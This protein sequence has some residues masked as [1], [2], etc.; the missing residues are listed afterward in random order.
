[1]DTLPEG[2]SVEQ[3]SFDEEADLHKENKTF[4]ATVSTMEP[5]TSSYSASSAWPTGD[6]EESFSELQLRVQ[7]GGALASPES[8]TPPR[9]LPGEALSLEE[10]PRTSGLI[11]FAPSPQVEMSGLEA[12]Q[13][14]E[15]PSTPDMSVVISDCSSSLAAEMFSKEFGSTV[16]S[17]AVVAVALEGNMD[18]DLSESS[19][20]GSSKSSKLV[21][22]YIATELLARSAVPS[23]PSTA[24]SVV[25]SE[26]RGSLRE[27]TAENGLGV[28]HTAEPEA[29][30]SIREEKAENG[31]DVS[32][33]AEPEARESIGAE[34][35]E[36]GLD[37]SQT[38]EPEV[39]EHGREDK[40]ENGLAV[41]PAAEPEGAAEPQA[42]ESIREEKAENGLDVSHPAEPEAENGLDVSQTAEPEAGE[43]TTPNGF[44]AL[45]A[46]LQEEE[47]D[48][49]DPAADDLAEQATFT[50]C[51]TDSV[52]RK[53]IVLLEPPVFDMPVAAA[54]AEASGP[55]SDPPSEATV[56]PEQWPKTKDELH[57]EMDVLAASLTAGLEI[58]AKDGDVATEVATLAPE[59]EEMQEMQALVATEP[60]PPAEEDT[61]RSGASGHTSAGTSELDLAT[62]LVHA[63]CQ[64]HDTP[65]EA[66]SVVVSQAT[67]SV[68]A[69]TMLRSLEATVPAEPLP[70]SKEELLEEVDVLAASLTDGLEPG[71]SRPSGPP[72]EVTIMLEHIPKTKDELLQEMDV[73]AASL[74]AGLDASPGDD[75]A[76]GDLEAEALLPASTS[77]PPSE[78]TVFLEQVPKSQDEL[79][80]E[81]N[82]LAASL[83]AGLAD[84]PSKNHAEDDGAE[85]ATLA[86]E[87]EEMQEMQALVDTEPSPPAAEARDTPRSGASGHTSARS[88][89]LD[90]ATELVH[91]A[92]QAQDTPQEALSVVVSQGTASVDA[93]AM[94]AMVRFSEDEATVPAE[95]LPK[96]KEELLEEVDVLAASLTDGL[97]PGFSRPSGPPSEVTIMLEHIPKTKDE[98]LQEM[99]VLAASLTAGLDASPGDNRAEGDLEAEA[100]LPASTS[101]PPSEAT[102]FLEQVS[103][104]QDELHA[105]INVLAA[106]LTAGLADIPSKNHAEDDAAE[107]ATLAPEQEEMQEMQALV[108]TEPSPPAAEARDTPRS[109]ASGH[110]SARSSELDLATELVHAACQ[111]QDTP[112]EA[113]SVVVSQATAID[114]TEMV[115][116]LQESPEVRPAS[117]GQTSA[118][119]SEL[120]L[121]KEL[122]H[123]ACQAGDTPQEALSVVVSQATESVEATRIRPEEVLV[124]R[125]LDAGTFPASSVDEAT[126]A[127]PL[128]KSKEEL[129]EEVDVLAASLTDG[130]EPGFSRPSGP[131]SEVT[132]MLEH[133]PKT[134]DELL[135]EMDV[136]AASLT[137]GLDASPGDDR[138][139][140]DL[141]A[142]APV[143]ERSSGPP[144]EATVLLEHIPKTKEELLQEM[145]VLAASL[146]AGLDASPGE[147]RAEGG[148]E[149]EALLPAST[150]SPPS[151][152]TVFLEQVPKSQ[153]ELHAEINVL[154]A[155]LTAGLAEIPGKNHAEDDAAEVATLA[156]EQEEMQEM[157]ALVD[158]EP[159]PP[160]AEA[161]DTPRSGASGQ[162]SARTSELDL[163]TE[164]VHAACYA[165]DSPQEAV[166]VVVSQASAAAEAT[167][168]IASLQEKLEARRPSAGQS[169]TG[170]SELDLAKELVQAACYA[171]D[172]SQEALSV[173]VSQASAAVDAAVMVSALKERLG[174]RP[175]SAGTAGSIPA[176]SLG[177]DLQAAVPMPIIS[178][179]ASEASVL[180]EPPRSK[181]LLAMMDNLAQ[182]L[183]DGL[184]EDVKQVQPGSSEPQSSAKDVAEQDRPASG[185]FD[186][187]VASVLASAACSEAA[188]AVMQAAYEEVLPCLQLEADRRPSRLDAVE[189]IGSVGSEDSARVG[190]AAAAKL[191]GE[192]ADAAP[193]AEAS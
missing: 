35:A 61:P 84:I 13:E 16:G 87:Q 85:V 151:E 24:R 138:A 122:V 182:S 125:P 148:L 166:S 181:E 50:I 116:S 162:T 34:Q 46:E 27:D 76:E 52:T 140:G 190:Q 47:E 93:A 6:L 20:R 117:A 167:E 130:L 124:A 71:F 89:E 161:R 68:E 176:S 112:Q 70:K 98:L 23:E 158:T 104:S 165:G 189:S 131:P 186:R 11:S 75:R 54:E 96:S 18:E 171:G 72:S 188:E 57:Q 159:S 150:S 123:I 137:A 97:E 88:S 32:H 82:V 136:L 192:V 3:F 79:H 64:A 40:V 168:M 15:V 179:P 31:L 19:S 160:A 149:A 29:R 30:E 99:D 4:Q 8:S 36:N 45:L 111:A 10:T 193:S 69:E 63:A 48:E 86:P 107:V 74:T 170:S 5:G 53:S 44:D 106:S 83:T 139:E 33:A 175:L 94:V 1:M 129:L 22:Q 114:A 56:A 177:E 9:T 121:A 95:P 133:I 43:E 110:T 28:S 39:R 155:S 127:E 144:S 42:R 184:V 62:E 66:M 142:E 25:A 134:K 77:S 187:S 157:Q 174:V 145:D 109:G 164:L 80:A 173:V 26:V 163:A 108:D 90:L 92:C 59:Q 156:P 126:S 115:V 7:P 49:H 135:Q 103:K 78:A 14:Q 119:T 73:L 41:A 65:Q 91:A 55:S 143:P 113:L 51:V 180:L 21:G 38:A 37:V 128:P 60:S 101:S 152:A 169:S 102:V 191:L 67:V 118:G 81:I 178:G 146:T 147:D 12:L 120:E 105:E 153:D 154:A 172:S 2:V 17:V 185:G 183:I 132:I 100:L 141:E 58:P